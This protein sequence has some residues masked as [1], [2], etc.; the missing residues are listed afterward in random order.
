MYCASNYPATE[1]DYDFTKWDDSYF[2]FSDHTILYDQ[3][4]CNKIKSNSNLEYYEKHFSLDDNCIDA[5]NSLKPDQFKILIDN[6]K[7]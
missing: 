1:N 2:G 6:L 7:A 3:E 4:W 5:K